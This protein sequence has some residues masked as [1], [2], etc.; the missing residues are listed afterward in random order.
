MIRIQLSINREVYRDT[1]FC[2][3]AAPELANFKFR[4]WRSGTSASGGRGHG[5]TSL[6]LH[7]ERE[8]SFFHFVSADL[9]RYPSMPRP[10]T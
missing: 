3:T 10:C 1:F 7:P 8:R 4:H 6:C 2:Q 9:W 5:Y